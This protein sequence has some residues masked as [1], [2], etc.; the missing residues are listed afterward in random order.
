MQEKNEVHP[1]A[2]EVFRD[3]KISR[4]RFL[5]IG[6]AGLAG[7]TLLGATGCDVFGGSQG[8]G[9]GGSGGGGG[10]ITVNL[11]DSI[12]DLDPAI[13]TDEV[14]ANVSV[15][16]YEGLQRLDADDL[17]IPG[18]AES[19]DISEDK[20]TYTFSLR[21]AKWS[22]GDSV[23]SQD[24]KYGWLRVLNPDTAAQY[25]YIVAQFIEGAAEYNSGEGKAEDVAIETPDDKTLEV[26]LVAPAP[27]W[28][29]LTSFWTYFPQN[30]KFVEKQ[31]E[32]FGQNADSVLTNGPYT[33][34]EYN[35]TKG[36]TFVKSKDYWDADNVSI[37]KVESKI[38]KEI[39]TA[40]NLFESGDLDITEIT[41]EFVNEYQGKPEFNQATELTCFYMVFNEEAVPIFKNTNVR[42]AFQIGF[43][44]EAM[45]KQIINDGSVP[46]TGL[47]PAG[48]AGPDDQ[49]FR[50]AVG[51]TMPKF[52][53][54]EA[55][56]L[57]DQG[58][59]EEGGE[60]PK[61]ELLSYE[62]STARDIATFLQSQFEENLGIKMSVKIQPF[63]RKLELEAD[64]DFQFSYQGWGADYN[65]PMTF[66]DLWLS[67]SSFNTGSYKNEQ[68]DELINQAKKETDF[69]TRM[70]Q[71][72]EAEK[73]L[74]EEDAAC[75]PMF[76]QGTTR[77][78]RP[79]I[80][81]FV[82]HRSGGSLDLKLYS[83]ES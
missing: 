58:I 53:A 25:A 24:F 16:I 48:I 9:N 67:N 3:M 12:R 44:R 22:N 39:D 51:D 37:P 46:A 29:G 33:L 40:V 20:L 2:E 76:F 14:S 59:E 63:D 55:K 28:L 81:N 71:M 21:D 61:I 26:K 65:D 47:V 8:G 32:K 11:Q 66:L 45:V 42:K 17:P 74:I 72:S 54:Q 10:P 30:Q 70:D 4:R 36:A 18:M 41:Q 80:K 7:A 56:R 69:A 43:D 34:E 83:V 15:N 50:E 82:Y 60:V 64:G 62:T 79:S 73:L 78:I 19:V 57:F 49:T 35:P 52:D 6:G 77:L 5:Q 27:F 31:G 68:F 1:S 23:T 38:V 13:F 75:V